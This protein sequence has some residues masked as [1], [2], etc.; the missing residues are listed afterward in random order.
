MVAQQGIFPKYGE[1][2]LKYPSLHRCLID[3]A[4]A[5]RHHNASVHMPLIGAGQAKG[6]WEI[7]EGMIYQELILKDIDVTVYLLPGKPLKSEEN[8]LELF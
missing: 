6:N 8:K 2:P 5:A 1:V 3:L 4:E 7:I